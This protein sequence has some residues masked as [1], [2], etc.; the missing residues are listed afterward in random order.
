MQRKRL[1][2]GIVSAVAFVMALALFGYILRTDT[3]KMRYEGAALL[4][5][6]A[7]RADGSEQT[8]ALQ[9]EQRARMLYVKCFRRE[10]S[11]TLNGQTLLDSNRV[12]TAFAD[13][14]A[15]PWVLLPIEAGEGGTLSVRVT[16]SQN[17]VVSA[18]E[19]YMGTQ[20][21]TALFMVGEKAGATL[22]SIVM[23]TLSALM[24]MLSLFARVHARQINARML[25]WMGLFTLTSA[26]WIF[27]DSALISLYTGR[28]DT[29]YF[30]SFLSFMLLPIPLMQFFASLCPN[31]AKWFSVMSLA[32]SLSLIV[33]LVPV[34]AGAAMLMRLLSVTHVL[35]LLA[36]PVTITACALEIK[37]YKDKGAIAVLAAF[38]AL[39]AVAVAALFRFYT[40]PNADNTALFRV[41]LL[42]F[43]LILSMEAVRRAM[44]IFIHSRNFEMMAATVP[45]GVCRL[46]LDENL[47]IIYANAFFYRIFGYEKT[48]ALEKGLTSL[49]RVIYPPDYPAARQNV[50]SVLARRGESFELD[51][52]CVSKNGDLLWA[53]MRGHIVY[54]SENE[55]NAVLLDI[56]DRKKIDQQLRVREEEYRL[57]ALHSDKYIVRYD[58][59]TGTIYRQE[60]AAQKLGTTLV[61]AGVPESTADTTPFADSRQAYIDLYRR[62]REGEK[63]G[64]A[65]LHLHDAGGGCW[66]RAR[67]TTV[68][69]ADRKPLQAIISMEDVT[70][71]R[72]R[73]LAYE[74]W[75][76][77][78]EAMP[79]DR[80]CYLTMNLTKDRLEEQSGELLQPLA[81]ARDSALSDVATELIQRDIHPSDRL[82]ARVFCSRERLLDCAEHRVQSDQIECRGTDGLWLRLTVQ[83]LDDPYTH[84]S[85]AF[86]L[87]QD[88]SEE[89]RVRVH[90]EELL[91]KDNLTGA[92][93]RGAFIAHMR[94]TLLSQKDACGV[95]CYLDVDD[96]KHINDTYGHPFGDTVL[97]DA[98]TRISDA[99][100]PGEAVG[101]LGGDE[102]AVALRL[103]R[104]DEALARARVEALCQGMVSEYG[105]GALVTHSFGA[106]LFPTHG[107]TFEALYEKADK[108][109][110]TAKRMGKNQVMIYHKL[111]CGD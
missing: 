72:D 80:M 22:I 62:I 54:K 53:S 51:M 109:L 75:M 76:Q 105:N 92:L 1:Y 71:Q 87:V 111:T 57:A 74:K 34:I 78:Y 58:V 25:F 99:L 69:G 31:H 66:Y 68:F 91:Q 70:Q 14:Y 46:Q 21:D 18:P 65:I 45:C 67:F 8:Y 2:S 101:R 97:Q 77:Q 24:L 41:G 52:R 30:V 50:Q 7:S 102:F 84:D 83:L 81:C 35:M 104:P 63:E 55:L 40:N 17:A 88:V 56:T 59:Q 94:D 10:I 4:T 13:A 20:G 95:L 15:R 61:T 5:P 33:I 47:R 85:K 60:D 19:V 32:F 90:A 43:L 12:Q 39:G 93:N 9:S 16:D 23:L 49:E 107:D 3:P 98:V 27:S 100:L 48:E 79:R 86:L 36:V 89:K 28:I 110:Y 38:G 11:V 26:V 29:L 6:C 42:V 73:E 106:A 44:G 82:L 103:D 96:F 37:Q 64:E 108:A